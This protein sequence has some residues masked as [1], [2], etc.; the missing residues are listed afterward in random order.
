M[1]EFYQ[2]YLDYKGMMKFTEELLRHLA[3]KV[4]GT[5]QLTYQNMFIDLGQPFAVMTMKD[6]IVHY[7]PDISLQQLEDEQQARELA[8]IL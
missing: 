3:S 7:C 2:A 8:R 4:L 6:A 1:I 5:L